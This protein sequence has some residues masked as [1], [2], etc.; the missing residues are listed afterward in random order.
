M[1][2]AFDRFQP[3]DRG[4]FGDNEMAPAK[5]SASRVTGASDLR[6]L[7]L[8]RHHQTDAAVLVSSGGNLTRPVWLPKS[9]VEIEETGEFM[10]VWNDEY[11]KSAAVVVVTL[12]EWLA[13]QKGLI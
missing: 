7:R 4:M 6:D 3:S 8:A 13:K 12:P 10:H 2:D 5:P 9:K 11:R 1:R